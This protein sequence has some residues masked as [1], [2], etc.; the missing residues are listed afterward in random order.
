MVFDECC[1]P[2]TLR[3]GGVFRYLEAMVSKSASGSR[4]VAK[5]KSAARPRKPVLLTGGNPQI[6]KG[7]G[8]APVQKYIAAMPG[9]KRGI[10]R[11]I[12]AIVERVVPDVYKAVKWNS[13][14]YGFEG[15]GWF[16]SLHV[17][18]KYVQVTFFR[19]KSLD[20]VPSGESKHPHVRYYNVRENELD[21][22]LLAKWVKQ[23][24]Q[25]PGEKL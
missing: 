23:A 4:K 18:T 13:P 14:F 1:S 5:K 9:W 25:L 10:G 8:D 12:D 20:P 24:S 2:V 6:P 16:L 3:Q 22:A 7:Y 11:R 19:G 17:Y 15:K 21:E